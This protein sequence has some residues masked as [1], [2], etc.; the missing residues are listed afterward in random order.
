[1]SSYPTRQLGKT[2]VKV[3][4]STSPFKPVTYKQYL[5][6]FSRLWRHGHVLFLWTYERGRRE[7]QG[8]FEG[9]RYRCHFLGYCWYLWIWEKRRCVFHA[10]PPFI[11]IRYI[12]EISDNSNCG[13]IV[14][15]VV[16]KNGK[17]RWNFLGHQV[18]KYPRKWTNCTE[19]NA[20]VCSSGLCSFSRKIWDWVYWLVLL[21]SVMRRP[22]ANWMF[23]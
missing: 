18:W 6:R 5:P 15:K 10:F 2:G 20:R 1:M 13:R 12:S 16:Q 11:I 14:G 22:S 4:A 8:S 19:G 23:G 21:A 9:S 7:F 3:S 17:E